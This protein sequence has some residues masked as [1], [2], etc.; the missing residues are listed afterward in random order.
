M[1]AVKELGINITRMLEEE[2]VEIAKIESRKK[3]AKRKV[4]EEGYAENSE[5]FDRRVEV[6]M[7]TLEEYDEFDERVERRINKKRDEE[8][9]KRK[10]DKGKQKV[11]D[12]EDKE[13]ISDT[14]AF[15][16]FQ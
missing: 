11:R 7:R 2:Q 9:K 14:E 3:G 12:N 6:V 4:R 5:E 15:I 1:Q 10:N 8:E 16:R 13:G